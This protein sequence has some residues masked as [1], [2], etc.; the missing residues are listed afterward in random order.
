LNQERHKKNKN[1]FAP[2]SGQASAGVF[3]K[4]ME[5]EFQFLSIPRNPSGKRRKKA[6][7]EEARD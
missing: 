4:D 6:W 7:G 3:G 5:V 2:I 1:H